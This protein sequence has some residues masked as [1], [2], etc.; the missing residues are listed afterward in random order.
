MLGAMNARERD[1]R[2]KNDECILK[3]KRFK[4]YKLNLNV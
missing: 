3:K 4:T 1:K 2:K